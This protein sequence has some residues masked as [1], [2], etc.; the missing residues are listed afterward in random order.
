MV[1][2]YICSVNFNPAHYDLQQSTGKDVYAFVLEGA[3]KQNQTIYYQQ[4]IY[5]LIYSHRVFESIIFNVIGF[6]LNKVQR[7]KRKT[8]AK[9]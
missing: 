5:F 7:V 6:F 3:Y 2:F 9:F 4:I 1:Y 8:N